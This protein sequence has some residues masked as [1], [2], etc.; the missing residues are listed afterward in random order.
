[1]K[2]LLII[3]YI[4]CFMFIG[5][6]IY[7]VNTTIVPEYSKIN[8]ELCKFDQEEPI[9]IVEFT[10]NILKEMETKPKSLG[11]FRLTAY[12]DCYECQEEFIGITALGVAPRPNH[13]I[14]VDP[15]VIPLGSHV[16]INGIEYVAEDVGG[17]V[18]G[19]HI[20][21]F[22]GSHAETYSPQFNTYAEVFSVQ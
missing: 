11:L 1:M 10:N 18:K 21:V 20:D 2:K 15:N 14:A 19:N 13:T 4:L 17:G 16:L 3:S 12:D 5:Y 6:V 22:V 8:K 9:D 7:D